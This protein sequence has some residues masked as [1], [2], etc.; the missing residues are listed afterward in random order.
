M[1]SFHNNIMEIISSI[2]LYTL[3]NYFFISTSFLDINNYFSISI[4]LIFCFMIKQYYSNNKKVIELKDFIFS[5]C[6]VII[7]VCLYMLFGIYINSNEICI[8]FTISF[9]SI[10]FYTSQLRNR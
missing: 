8:L 1:I 10:I 4:F 2:L 3:L 5:I 6:F 9:I 7:L